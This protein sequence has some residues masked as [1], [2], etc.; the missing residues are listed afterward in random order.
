M[1][2][3][4]TQSKA[5]AAGNPAGTQ[6]CRNRNEKRSR[7]CS[8]ARVAR[9][10]QK[11]RRREGYRLNAANSLP[12]IRKRKNKNTEAGNHLPCVFMQSIVKNQLNVPPPMNSRNREFFGTKSRTP[13]PPVQ[14]I[15]EDFR[16]IAGFPRLSLPAQK[17]KKGGRQ[18]IAGK[19]VSI[20]NLAR[21]L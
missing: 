11:A 2:G 7:R 13:V 21:Y 4:G 10:E 20:S 12:C 3:Q 19:K 17:A 15:R 5:Q 6:R 14:E 8:A 16:E 1:S 18:L 9:T